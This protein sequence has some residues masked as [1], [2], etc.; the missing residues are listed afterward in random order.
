MATFVEVGNALLEISDKRLYRA[1]HSTFREY[2]EDKWKMSARRAYQLC[3]A[4]EVV[5]SLTEN[6][7]HGSQINERQAREL[8]KVPADE[9]VDVMQEAKKRG[10]V[11]A[12]SIRR[13]HLGANFRERK[14]DTTPI[15]ERLGM[16]KKTFQA[17]MHFRGALDDYA[18][19]LGQHDPGDVVSGST[20]EDREAITRNIKLVA[21][22]HEKLERILGLAD[23]I[24]LEPPPALAKFNCY[25]C[26]EGALESIKAEALE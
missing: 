12:E 3:E 23:I 25:E 26:G 2:V 9:R 6:V 16:T 18:K 10:K 14:I 11:T 21:E 13:I 24:P 8:A 15:Y 1:T 22:Y 4:A 19:S 5:K 20:P 17:G 7:N